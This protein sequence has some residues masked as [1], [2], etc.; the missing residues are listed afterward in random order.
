ME[1]KLVW[2]FFKCAQFSKPSK[3]IAV[4]WHFLFVTGWLETFHR[5]SN[6]RCVAKLL[7]GLLYCRKMF[8]F[9]GV[10]ASFISGALALLEKEVLG[11]C[12]N[13]LWNLSK[14]TNQTQPLPFQAP[15]PKRHW[16][17]DETSN[18]LRQCLGAWPNLSVTEQEVQLHHLRNNHF[19]IYL[20]LPLHA[21]SA[22]FHCCK[23]YFSKL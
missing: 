21:A 15:T 18:A 16:V 7:S 10:R 20:S 11:E 8:L 5:Q 23:M 13:L 19:L 2:S 12:Y 22:A 6:C 9:E 3:V 17:W 1:G 4:E 14:P